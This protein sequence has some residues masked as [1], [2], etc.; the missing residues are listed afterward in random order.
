MLFEKRA[1]ASTRPLEIRIA[2]WKESPKFRSFF[3]FL[4]FFLSSNGRGSFA[5]ISS[6]AAPRCWLGAVRCSPP[7]SACGRITDSSKKNPSL[8]FFVCCLLSLFYSDSARSPGPPLQLTSSLCI[9]GFIRCT[10][11]I[12]YIRQGRM[13]LSLLLLV[14]DARKDPRIIVTISGTN[15]F[16]LIRA[17]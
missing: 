9:S 2:W 6:G 15:F 5:Y 10:Y 17:S 1:R 8:F 11:Y 7:R 14:A 13:L 4:F 16:P 3:F 12:V